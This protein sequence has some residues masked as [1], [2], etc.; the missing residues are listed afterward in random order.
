MTA[1][2]AGELRSSTEARAADL[3]PGVFAV[4]MATGIVATAAQLMGIGPL[5]WILLAVNIVT[6]TLLVVLSIMRILTAPERVRADFRSHASAPGFFTAVAG[7]CVLGTQLVV[8]ADW[9]GAATAL[10]VVGIVLWVGLIYGFFFTMTTLPEKPRLEEG[11]NGSW[12]LVVVA[13][14]SVSVLGSLLAPSFTDA[15]ELALSGALAL[16]LLGCMF[17]L[18]LFSLILLRFL[19]FAFDPAKLTP[20]YW[21]N[22]GAVA[23]TTLAGSL[24]I[25]RAD[26]WTFITDILPFLRGFTLLFW[27]TATWWIPL[28]LLLGAWRH[29]GRRV[30]LRY[31][32][33]YWSMVFPLGM[34]AVATFRLG[35]ALGWTF[36][37]P[38]PMVFGYL[39]IG[40]WSVTALGLTRRL[41]LGTRP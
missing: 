15:R 10:W 28:L 9:P 13:T 14:Q 20:P 25:L 21:I 19:F 32:L 26:V 40:A 4:V 2:A 12:M 31:D 41:L 37:A 16:F 8:L 5:A 11:L 22:M 30:P 7:T 27:A 6:Y 38:L 34:Y 1:T 24:L 18:L 33:Q 29:V 17:Y 3:P 35:E 39:A 36:L 23:I